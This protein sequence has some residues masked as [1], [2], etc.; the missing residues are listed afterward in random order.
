MSPCLQISSFSLALLS[1][2]LTTVQASPLPPV[3]SPMKQADSRKVAFTIGCKAPE[4][5][6]R[7]EK[8]EVVRLSE[9]A[10]N[11]PVVLINDSS[12]VTNNVRSS[13]G[14]SQTVER[15]GRLF[16]PC[17]TGRGSPKAAP[18]GLGQIPILIADMNIAAGSDH[19][20]IAFIIDRGGVVA[21]APRW[22]RDVENGLRTLA[23]DSAPPPAEA[24]KATLTPVLVAA[25]LKTA[26]AEGKPML[27][28]F[29]APECPPCQRMDETLEDSQ[30]K[31]ALG[32]Y[33]LIKASLKRHDTWD[34]FDALRMR[35]TPS[36]VVIGPDGEIRAKAEG[37]VP[38][39]AFR[40]FLQPQ[41][42]SGGEESWWASWKARVD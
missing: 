36:F 19:P 28:E 11:L 14:D 16:H 22:P 35:Q 7:T 6:L 12:F 25:L 17:G 21:E 13:Q 10:A 39:S 9:M 20:G 41:S 8:G 34:L 24:S 33:A 30:V 23:G 4:L 1:L 38:P 37:E 3:S 26:H 32:A 40:Q 5:R 2:S 31:K 42:S 18:R 27:V 29:T 15:Q